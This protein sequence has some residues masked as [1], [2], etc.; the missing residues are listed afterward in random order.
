MDMVVAARN[1]N[2]IKTLFFRLFFD[3]LKSGF[4]SKMR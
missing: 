3:Q 2:L 1:R 4:S